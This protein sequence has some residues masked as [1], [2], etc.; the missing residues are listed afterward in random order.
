MLQTHAQVSSL[1][2]SLTWFGYSSRGKTKCISV[3]SSCAAKHTTG[4]RSW[5]HLHLPPYTLSPLAGAFHTKH[6]RYFCGLPLYLQVPCH[7]VPPVASQ[8][9]GT[10]C[11]LVHD[12]P[13][14]LMRPYTHQ[15]WNQNVQCASCRGVATPGVSTFLRTASSAVVRRKGSRGKMSKNTKRTGTSTQ[16]CHASPW[17]TR[18]SRRSCPSSQSWCASCFPHSS[19]APMQAGEAQTA[20]TAQQTAQPTTIPTQAA[21][22]PSPTWAQ[23]DI[24]EAAPGPLQ[25]LPLQHAGQ[26]PMPLPTSPPT[27]QVADGGRTP[28]ALTGQPWTSP[29]N[30]GFPAS[31]ASEGLTP[32]QVPGQLK[33]KIQRGEYVDLSELLA[34][35]FQ[36]WYSG[37][38][39]SQ[40]LEVV[41][42]KLSLAPRRKNRHLSNLQL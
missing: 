2:G 12:A 35:N 3:Y 38:D 20:S 17:R 40:A 30:T 10:K 33:G 29:A 16:G 26:Q 5:P 28:R 6:L 27:S 14:Y 24:P 15:A 11:R 9:R 31:P 7:A 23:P 4:Q 13:Y 36:Y 34:C 8:C 42:G 19:Q 1:Q 18:P 32:A 37:L 22:L 39:D 25:L 21:S 41:D